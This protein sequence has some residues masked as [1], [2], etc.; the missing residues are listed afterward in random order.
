LLHKI[1]AE[2]YDIIPLDSSSSYQQREQ[3]K[4]MGYVAQ[5][6]VKKMLHFNQGVKDSR[7]LERVL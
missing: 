7:A 3:G 5:F 2:V 1:R 6:I 4:S